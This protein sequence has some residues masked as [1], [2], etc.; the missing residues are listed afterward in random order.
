MLV[1]VRCGVTICSFLVQHDTD[2]A[3][4][5]LDLASRMGE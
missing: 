5:K 2:V 3:G 4:F 1:C